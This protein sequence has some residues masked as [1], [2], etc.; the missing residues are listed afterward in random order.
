[1]YQDVISISMNQSAPTNSGTLES[2]LNNGDA[3]LLSISMKPDGRFIGEDFPVGTNQS[4][5]VE[6]MVSCCTTGVDITAVDVRGNRKTCR[7]DQYWVYLRPG[8]IAAVVLGALFLLLIIIIVIVLIVRCCK[9]RKFR[10]VSTAPLPRS[11]KDQ[12]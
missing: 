9:R 11:K 3:G 8:E 4:V 7:A 12:K 1:V 10:S 6:R 2:A 5:Q